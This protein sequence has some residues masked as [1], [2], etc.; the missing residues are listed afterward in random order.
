MIVVVGCGN[1]NR[2]D[3]GVGCEVLRQLPG[4]C[5]SLEGVHILDAGTDG[6]AVMYA[7][8][9]ADSLIIVDAC[10][11]GSE[12]GAVFK[13]PGA[14]LEQESPPDLNLHA[15]RW[16]HAL[17]AGRRMLGEAFPSDVTVFLIEA[18]NT[19]FGL[20][21]SPAVAAAAPKAAA[22]IAAEIALRQGAQP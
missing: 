19:A 20:E 17:Y 15:F 9:G 8:R 22:Q 16:D 7:A 5:A 3:D 4:L 1:P 2:S 12:P 13:A 18:E 6:M 14:A 21:L 11:S 10:C